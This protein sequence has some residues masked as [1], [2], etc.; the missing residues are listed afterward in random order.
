M[1]IMFEGRYSSQAWAGVNESAQARMDATTQLAA[2]VGGTMEAMYWCPGDEWDFVLIVSG[3]DASGVMAIKKVV[4][5]TGA[6]VASRARVLL[7]ADEFDAAQPGTYAA[8]N[9]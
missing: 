4:G 5:A 8:P 1:K 2:S 7:D 3:L 9:A 6:L